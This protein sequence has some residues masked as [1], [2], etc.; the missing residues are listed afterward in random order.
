MKGVH[1]AIR[2]KAY[3]PNDPEI[4]AAANT[5][6]GNLRNQRDYIR[7]FGRL[8]SPADDLGPLIDANTAAPY[9]EIHLASELMAASEP[10]AE[11]AYLD[12]WRYR[13]NHNTDYTLPNEPIIKNNTRGFWRMYDQA[14][15]QFCRDDAEWTQEFKNF[16]ALFA[17]WTDDHAP[18]H[19]TAFSVGLTPAGYTGDNYTYHPWTVN[20]FGT[21]IGFGLQGDTVPVVGAYFAY[22]DG[23][24]QAMKGSSTYADANLLTRISYEDRNWVMDS[25]SP[26]DHQYGGYALGEILAPGSI[27]KT[28][29]LHTYLDPQWIPEGNGDKTVEFSRMV[30]RQVWATAD[31]TTWDSLGF[32]YSPF[33]VPAS[34]AYT[35]F[36]VT[37]AEGELLDPAAETALEQ[38]YNVAADFDGTLYIV[39]AVSTNTAPLRARW[40]NGAIFLSEQTGFQSLEAVKPA[41]ATTLRTDL[42]GETFAQISVVLD[43]KPEIFSNAGFELGDLTDWTKYTQTGITVANVADPRLEGSRALELKATAGTLNRKYGQ[44]YHEYDI[45]TDPTN[46]HYVLEFDLLTENLEGSSIRCFTQVYSSSNTVLRTE[47]FDTYEHANSQTMLSAGFRKRDAD[48]TTFRFYIRFRRDDASAVTATERVLIDNLRL[49][50]M[51]P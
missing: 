41:G 4:V 7:E 10:M 50:K 51:Q 49:L 32:Q 12:Y 40:Y 47:Y 36:A 42:S 43:G 44:V 20:S 17:G 29:A 2:A 30:R 48:H 21:V 38:E 37:G 46:T 9:Q 39:R 15:I 31:G 13:E 11:N 14:T 1:M 5:I 23:R 18:E 34:S 8:A 22:R 16:Y 26:T 33:T 25:M 45:S 27:E 19:L 28:I 3:Y 35:N 6:I 24:R